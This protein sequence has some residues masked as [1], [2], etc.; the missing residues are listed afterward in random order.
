MLKLNNIK[1][2]SK[3]LFP[4]ISLLIVLVTICVLS[5]LF[6][7]S[8]SNTLINDLYDEMHKSQYWL[9]NADRDFYQS[10]VDHMNVDKAKEAGDTDKIDEIINSYEE[11]MAHSYDRVKLAQDILIKDQQTYTKYNLA[12]LF[13]DFYIN[14]E[15]W[16]AYNNE[17]DH[18]PQREAA[19]VLVFNAAR[20]NIDQLQETLDI[21]S[22]GIVQ[23]SSSAVR[24]MKI[25]VTI[26]SVIAVL[27]SLLLSIVVILN[28]NKRT[29]IAVDLL[30]TTAAFNL[31][32]DASLEK[33]YNDKDEFGVIISSGGKV[34]K[35]FRHLVR[36]V[37]E[38]MEMLNE[39]VENT[40]NRMTNLENSIEDISATTEQLSA[41]M[42]E[43]AA[44]TEEM[45]ATSTEIESAIESIAEKAQN[46]SFTAYEIN[47][48]A[49]SLKENFHSS[50]NKAKEI[51]HEVNTKL[52]QALEDSKAVAQINT[53]ADAIMQI[54]TQTNLLALNAAIEAARAGE[55]GK[56]FAVVADEIRKLAEDSKNTVSEIQ[57][58]TKVVTNSVE[59][60]VENSNE[61]LT[62]VSN[63]VNADYET[64][65]SATEQYNKDADSLNELV[66]DLSS[67]SEE[68]LASIQNM[69][70][71]IN[72]VSQAA[73][74]G[75]SGTANIAGRTSSII[76][77]SSDVAMSLKK[78]KE[79]VG[80]LLQRVSKFQ[81]K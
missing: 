1:L 14:Y 25:N 22:L 67:T 46:G 10:M 39:I 18:N 11:N 52:G 12:Q 4:V 77:D 54:A 35:E 36:G 37:I 38:E 15:A 20:D 43:T 3:I 50:Y 64:M 8:L 21:H 5:I 61:L 17:L 56:G 28:I 31:K 62:F 40:D 29:K 13:D 2:R 80:A 70:K 19:S 63:D 27:F 6:V 74:E 69:L 42:Q 72:E 48:R 49:D 45:N 33:Y 79:T 16:K 59:N 23:K 41:G 26:I 78:T 75:A 60:L 7:Q 76:H 9:L 34:R 55:A 57:T 51:F 68:L 47:R 66:T 24:N 32:Y 44:S 71:A 81:I 65:L 53:L 30:E 58:V 73:N